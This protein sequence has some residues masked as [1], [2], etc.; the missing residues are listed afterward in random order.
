MVYESFLLGIVGDVEELIVEVLQIANTVFVKASLP[1]LPFVLVPDCEGE[2]SFDELGAFFNRF[3]RSEKNMKV[4]RHDDETMKEVSVLFAVEVEEGQKEFGVGGSLK[5]AD[6]IMS[7]GGE[8]VGL[9]VEA[10]LEKAYLR[11]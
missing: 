7:D 3:G 5:Y 2:A 4:I 11:G 10:H 9:R 8:R 6:A 1:Y